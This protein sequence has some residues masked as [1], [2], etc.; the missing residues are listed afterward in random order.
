[1]DKLDFVIFDMD[2]LLFDTET[3]AFKAFK[4]TLSKYGYKF[5]IDIF[6]KMIGLGPGEDEIVLK[7]EYGDDFIMDTIE[8]EFKARFETLLK[9]EGL[10]IKPGTYELLKA[11]D[12]YSIDRCIASSSSRKTIQSYLEMSNLENRFDFYISGDEVKHGKPYPDIFLEACDRA[13]KKTKHAIVLED[14]YNGFLAAY[15][16]GINCVIVPDIIE[17]NTKIKKHAYQIVNNLE[18]VVPLIKRIVKD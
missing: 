1:M 18:E 8:E 11:L 14:S 17:P 9:S 15:R 5:T 10:K 4:D 7:T 13:G 6:K 3:I 16:A 12:D 2:G